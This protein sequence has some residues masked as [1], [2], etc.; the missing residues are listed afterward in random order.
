M[1]C[2][3]CGIEQSPSDNCINCGIVFSKYNEIQERK[4]KVK[5]GARLSSYQDPLKEIP[6]NPLEEISFGGWIL[7][8]LI[9]I[10]GGWLIWAT[11]TH[12]FSDNI[13]D[14]LGAIVCSIVGGVVIFWARSDEK[15]VSDSQTWPHV[16][17]EIFS[18]TKA[19][20]FDD[21]DGVLLRVKYEY[22]VG[23]KLYTINTVCIGRQFYTPLLGIWKFRARKR[24]YSKGQMVDVFYDPKNPQNSCLEKTSD[25]TIG[26]YI[27]GGG[28]IMLGILIIT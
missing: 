17:C 22:T 3:K 25:G 19:V 28:F 14:I 1:K 27:V 15:K 16:K 4:H 10:F 5:G 20:S 18:S 9:F 8:G 13:R 7:M 12:F 21:E 2:P 23:S 11:K 24:K 26:M 6:T